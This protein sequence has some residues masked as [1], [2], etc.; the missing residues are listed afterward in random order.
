MSP[1][2]GRIA[3]N[4]EEIKVE[5]VSFFENFMSEQPDEFD[6]STVERLRDL[7]G[8]QCSEIDCEKLIKD[9][10]KEEIKCILFKMPGSKAPGPDGYTSEFFKESWAVIGDDIT[11]AVQSFFDKGF[12]HREE[13]APK[14]P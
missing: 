14:S 3:K 1:S 2:D 11:V 13:N 8:F 9:V 5:A 6:G 10:S 7:L 12:L 4:K